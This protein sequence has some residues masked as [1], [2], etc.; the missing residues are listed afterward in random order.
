[1]LPV[2]FMITPTMLQTANWSYLWTVLAWL[3]TGLLSGLFSILTSIVA[4]L[5][6]VTDK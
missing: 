1:M 3:G 2:E 6:E 5:P 4:G